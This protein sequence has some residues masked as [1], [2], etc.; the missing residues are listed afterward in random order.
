VDWSLT[1]CAQAQDRNRGAVLP[2]RHRDLKGDDDDDEKGVKGGKRGMD[3]DD[4][5]GGKGVKGGSDNDDDDGKRR[6]AQS[7]SLLR[8][9]SSRIRKLQIVNDLVT[10]CCLHSP[11]VLLLSK[12]LPMA[13]ESLNLAFLDDMLFFSD[14]FWRLLESSKHHIYT[15]FIVNHS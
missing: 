12:S 8:L 7:P 3:D 5:D 10:V 9:F 13:S 6:Q 15:R 1:P 14:W 2:S 4:D 11:A